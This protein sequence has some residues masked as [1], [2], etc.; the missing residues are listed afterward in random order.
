M[1]LNVGKL[2]FF[3]IVIFDILSKIDPPDICLLAGSNITIYH[4]ALGAS[5]WGDRR[6]KTWGERWIKTNKSLPK[7]YDE[8]EKIIKKTASLPWILGD[9]NILLDLQRKG[10]LN[11]ECYENIK[12]Y[13]EQL[14]DIPLEVLKNIA[15]G[16]YSK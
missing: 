15:Y 11:P 1:I 4:S 10:I 8:R 12:M 9:I 5:G 14:S 2:L 16:K 3:F 6:L 13:W 7:C